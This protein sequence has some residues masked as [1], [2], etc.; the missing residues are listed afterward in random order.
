MRYFLQLSYNGAGFCGWQIQPNGRTVQ[1]E[2]EKALATVLRQPTSI[3]GAGRTDAGVHA[4]CMYAH[5]DTDK[6]IKDPDALLR[7]LNH[8]CGKQ[9]SFHRLISV[10]PDAHAR[11]DAT[12]RTYKYFL[13]DCKSPFFSEL[14]WHSPYRLDFEAMNKAAEILL[15]TEDFTSFAKLHTDVKTNICNVTAAKWTQVNDTFWMFTITADR[16]LRNMV[17][18]VVGTL[19]EVGRGRLS[20]DDFADI[21][22]KRDRCAAG[23]SMPAHALY[24][25]DVKY[26]YID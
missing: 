15:D 9:I 16:F 26:P 5:F 2:I 6:P 19:V 10:K 25:W 13:T 18:A 8:M 17:R 7:S 20:L 14:V 22:N 1:Q 23:V 3:V 21:I 12:E 4:R 11:F 24:L